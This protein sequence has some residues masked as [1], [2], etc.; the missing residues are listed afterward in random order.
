[1]NDAIATG[2]SRPAPR[3]NSWCDFCLAGITE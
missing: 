3:S 1:M 2:A